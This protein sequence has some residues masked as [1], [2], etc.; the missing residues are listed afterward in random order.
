MEFCFYLVTDRRLLPKDRSLEQ[1]LEAAF[2]A[3]VKGVLLREKDLPDA[4]LVSLARRVRDLTLRYEVKMLVS[5]RADIAALVGAD[6]VHLPAKGYDVK[7]ARELVGNRYIAVSTHS[8]EEALKAEEDGADFVTFG[9]VFKTPS[10][11]KFG[12]PKGLDLLEELCREVEIPVFAVGGMK[13]ENVSDVIERGAFGIAAISA[14]FGTKD[15]AMA[16]KGIMDVIRSYRM[17][18]CV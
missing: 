11:E 2:S 15:P 6:G 12:K 18:R 10:K 4:E 17:G 16:V 5:A 8:I 3:G 13:A 1:I 14:V 7:A 9:P